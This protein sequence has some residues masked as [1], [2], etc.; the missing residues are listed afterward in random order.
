MR[1][2]A[3][4]IFVVAAACAA[5]TGVDLESEPIL[6]IDIPGWSGGEI[7]ERSGGASPSITKLYD[8]TGSWESASVALAET[9]RGLGW[10]IQSINCVGTG[11]DVIALHQVGDEWILLESGVGTRGAGMILS[12][13]SE[14]PTSSSLQVSGSCALE[15]VAAAGG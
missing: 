15:F 3:I 1:A 14:R 10:R 13:T 11:N 8:A 6:H 2:G 12:I 9:V 5:N 4:L 7:T